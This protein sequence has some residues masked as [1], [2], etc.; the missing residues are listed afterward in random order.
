MADLRDPKLVCLRLCFFPKV[1]SNRSPAAIVFAER[2][3]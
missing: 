3:R 1:M 2:L